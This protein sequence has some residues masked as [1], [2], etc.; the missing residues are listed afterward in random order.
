MSQP[1]LFEFAKEIG[2]ETLSLMDKL[3][4]WNIPIKNHMAEL[5]EETLK[6]IRSH[7]LLESK[8]G[9]ASKKKKVRKKTTV[10]KSQAKA[11]SSGQKKVSKKKVIRRKAS[12]LPS[13]K[14]T[15]ARVQKQLERDALEDQQKSQGE[16]KDLL[17]TGDVQSEVNQDK[18]AGQAS[19]DFKKALQE[20]QS[21]VSKQES[22]YDTEITGKAIVGEINL[23]QAAS[24]QTE[25][26][27]SSVNTDL[28]Q[29]GLPPTKER[30]G[31]KKQST[32]LKDLK[33]T[34]INIQRE[35]SHSLFLGS[36]F[37]KREVIFQPKKKNLILDRQIQ[38]TKVTTPAAH[39]RVVKLH[40]RIAV[41]DFAQQMQVKSSQLI[42][43]LVKNGVQANIH[44]VL[45]SETASLIASEF[46]YETENVERTL[47]DLISDAS[48]G[49][50]KAEEISRTPIVTVMGHID[51]GKTTLLDA[52]RKTNVVLGEAGSI[53]QHIGA[54]SVCLNGKKGEDKKYITFID[55]P[56]H[57]VFTAMRARG[58]NITDITIIVIAADDGI[59]PQTIEAINHAKAAKIPIIVAV[60]KMDKPEANIEKIRQEATQFDLVSEEW[61]GSTIFVPISAPKGEGISD[62]LETILLVSEMQD[63]RANPKRSGTGVVI[64]AQIKKGRGYVATLLIQDGSVSVG[65]YIV[66]GN[67]SGRIRAIMN[68]RGQKI[69]CAIPGM[70][71][72]I[73][74]LEGCPTAGDRFDI[75]KTESCVNEIIR[76]K[77]SMQSAKIT[78][79]H[80][81]MSLEDLFSNVKKEQ[82]STLSLVVKTDVSGT[83]E[84]IR[85][86]INGLLNKVSE[87]D[88][89][90]QVIHQAVGGI[91]ESDVLLASTA[92]GMVVGFNVRPDAGSV[93]LA[94]NEGVQIK[95]YKIIYE[96]M[97]DI[98]NALK[99]LLK[100]TFKEDVIG[101]LEVRNIFSISKIGTIAGCFVID[102]QVQRNSDVRLVRE[103]RVIY[104]GKI[105]SLKRFKE[106]VKEVATG[107]ECGLSIEKFNDIK[108][109]DA[110]EVFRMVEVPKSDI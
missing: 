40:G 19:E 6:V 66:A 91:S 81:Q 49:D 35:E 38:K 93:Q 42:A 9:K 28:L 51:H 67:V 85:E 17:L 22:K 71:V 45:D 89:D 98:E 74:G 86:A 29:T 97:K 77:K 73:L 11:I 75:C 30:E 82:I 110:I 4:Q 46:Q 78:T 25:S 57:E 101:H 27:H 52:I 2:M 18:K 100:P 14:Q 88:V 12:D 94:K 105:S 83:G 44:S 61:G 50:L 21:S 36:E 80:S 3:R 76:K 96:L 54:Y 106:D 99:G 23:N 107:F 70:P 92:K 59:M 60:S 33:T 5:D 65:Q 24:N 8:K 10:Q 90:V 7:L 43:T 56:G 68:D 64:E 47:E 37:R 41:T 32:S 95:T 72:E 62:L 15:Y 87:R 79:P 108:V 34:K 13:A 16:K 39:K 26:S 103:G 1:K 104:E 69:T 109:G 84:A 53:T 63:L 31:H 48:F 55:T 102:G 58:A 20:N